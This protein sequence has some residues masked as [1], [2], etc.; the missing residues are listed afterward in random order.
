MRRRCLFWKPAR[1][2]RAYVPTHL[3]WLRAEVPV[4]TVACKFFWLI[5]KPNCLTGFQ[6]NE[7]A[8]LRVSVVEASESFAVCHL[9]LVSFA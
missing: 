4:Q 2:L 9:R 3:H 6:M 8:S 5:V 1:A 7:G